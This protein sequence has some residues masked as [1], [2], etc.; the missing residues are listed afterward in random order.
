MNCIYS[1]NFYDDLTFYRKHSHPISCELIYVTN[2][3]VTIVSGND[4]YV[5]TE[6]HLCLIPPEIYHASQKNS[7]CYNRWTIFINPL[8]LSSL[9]VSSVIQ[10]VVSG[11]IIKKPLICDFSDND[12]K[13]LINELFNEYKNNNILAEDIII[14]RLIYL[15]SQLIRKSCTKE[16]LVAENLSTTVTAIQMYIQ[17]NCSL[18]LKISDIAENFFLSKSYLTHI[19]TEHSGTSPKQFLINCRLSKAQHM[20]LDSKD[21]INDISEK[22]GFASASDMTKRFRLRFGITPNEFRKNAMKSNKHELLF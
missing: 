9:T 1:M 10:G 15:I 4:K 3:S 5:L 20:L 13:A 2:G 19:F 7:D 6:N 12:Q 17:K 11:I 14:S 18:P 21:S 22:C 16:Q 8:S